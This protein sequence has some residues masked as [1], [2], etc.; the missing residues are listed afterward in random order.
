MTALP[1]LTLRD[2][3]AWSMNHVAAAKW[4]K[5]KSKGKKR[6]ILVFGVLYFGF[7]MSATMTFIQYQKTEP[8][9]P[10]AFI[11]IHVLTWVFSGALYGWMMWKVFERQ[12]RKYLKKHQNPKLNE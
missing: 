5:E 8:I 4:E 11:V 3:F 12:Y 6:F 7:P 1:K 10:E 2:R 9:H